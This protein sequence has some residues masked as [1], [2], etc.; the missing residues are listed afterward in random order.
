MEDALGK[1]WVEMG[2]RSRAV[3]E[4]EGQAALYQAEMGTARPGRGKDDGPK[5]EPK[6]GRLRHWWGQES[7]AGEG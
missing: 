5:L 3:T 1:D 4:A 6:A 2:G 7:Q